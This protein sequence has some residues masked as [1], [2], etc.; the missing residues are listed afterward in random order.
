MI[1]CQ[2]K[3]RSQVAL[4]FFTLS[5]SAVFDGPLEIKFGGRGLGDF[6]SEF[7]D[8]I[9]NTVMPQNRDWHEKASKE[10]RSTQ[11]HH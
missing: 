1:G 10:D 9:L 7:L 5:K 8:R 4:T 11:A 2:P 3:C 6:L